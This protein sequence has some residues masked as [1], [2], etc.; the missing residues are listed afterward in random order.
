MNLKS[1]RVKFAILI[2][3]PLIIIFILLTTITSLN[4]KK[5]MLSD[6]KKQ[7]VSTNSML[8]ES[9][10][11]FY[12][13]SL[14]LVMSSFEQFRMILYSEGSFSIDS[15]AKV[16]VKAINQLTQN[17]ET[18]DLPLMTYNG[19]KVYGNYD[20]VDTMVEQTETEGMTATIFQVFDKGLIR[21]TT[22]VHTLDGKRAVNTYIP[23]DSEV[24]KTISAGNI[25][26]G[27]AFV[28]S[29]WYWTVYAPIMENGRLIGALFI[30]I[31]EKVLLE[32]LHGILGANVGNTGKPFIIGSDGAYI[33][34]D[35]VSKEGSSALT[36][37]SDSGETYI[38]SML[39]SKKGVHEFKL[40]G[41]PMLYSYGTF[42]KTGWLVVTGSQQSEFFETQR[43][44]ILYLTITNVFALMLMGI[45][46]FIITGVLSKDIVFL[47]EVMIDERDLTKKFELKREDE[48]GILAKIMNAFIS[49]LRDIIDQVKTSTAELSSSNNQLAS[50]TEELSSTFTQQSVELRSIN[51]S[52]GTIRNNTGIVEQNLEKVAEQTDNTVYKTKDGARKLDESMRIVTE[53]KSNVSEL[54]TTVKGLSESS[55]Q[56]GNI[57]SVID[58][59]ADQT[60]LLALNA[61]IEAARAGE[62]G[63]G[64]AVVADEVRKLAE[65]TQ[66]ATHEIDKIINLLQGETKSV[67]ETM[68]KAASTVEVGVEVISTAK[69][70]F[71]DIVH[72][73]DEIKT[74]NNAMV[75]SVTEQTGALVDI[76]SRL[77]CLTVGIEQSTNA[78]HTVSETV[79]HLQ[80]QADDLLVM[81][82]RFKTE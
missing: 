9:I 44:V 55:E 81:T 22:N 76:S 36:E 71:D 1:I 24:Y 14:R 66:T 46:I 8:L 61:A 19:G 64:F 16:T 54:A 6:A 35:D 70:S 25:Y 27:R 47:K 20:L 82:E 23:V 50:T 18:V 15:E 62:A 79:A 12:Q 41:T 73:M 65:K 5:E 34:H 32:S 67:T 40:S 21:I 3:G 42:D 13:Q 80:R 33:H 68:G 49:N 75:E 74:V 4:I 39:K 51:H 43:K 38:Q 72:A 58:D 11:I 63:R 30:G 69:E 26:R 78:V 77:D 29:G 2:G 60:N 48:L 10:D 7:L 57:I 45:V 53:I 28:V 56:I 17:E 52:I 59:I 37:K 31:D